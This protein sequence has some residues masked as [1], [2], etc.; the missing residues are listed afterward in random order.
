MPNNKKTKFVVQSRMVIGGK[1]L[2]PG[3]RVTLDY[4]DTQVRGWVRA[5]NIRLV[6]A[7]K[8]GE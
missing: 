7:K 3:D 6:P 5:G 8:K 1:V 4:T 2:K